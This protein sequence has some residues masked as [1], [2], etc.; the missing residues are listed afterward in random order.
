MSLKDCQFN[1]LSKTFGLPYVI[2]FGIGWAGKTTFIINKENDLKKL[3]IK[4]PLTL[5]VI[6]KYI[7]GFTV[8]NN[9]CIYKD[10]IYISPPAI[11]LSNIEGLST[12]EGETNGRQWPCS[13]IDNFQK[14]KIYDYSQVIG[15]LLKKSN[16][17]GYFG[18]DF[19]VDKNYG[20]VYLSELNARLTASSSF[21]TRLEY[22]KKLIPLFVYH[23]A[24]FLKLDVKDIDYYN[25]SDLIKGSQ[26]DIKDAII[27][28]KFDKFKTVGKFK[29]Y[30][31]Q[32][33][34]LNNIYKPELLFNN[35]FYLIKSNNK[36]KISEELVRLET[37]NSVLSTPNQLNG[38]F[39]NL[40][41]NNLQNS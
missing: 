36:D 29:N 21:Y 32:I 27:A 33:K 18:L 23:L 14:S 35:E 37:K 39:K 2:Q 13:F 3:Q 28:K 19:I 17:L 4:Y 5:A 11:Q 31:S 22:S 30:N 1:K 12:K 16:Y 20:K 25:Q 6:S 34:Y 9:C 24:G 8:L 41:N 7:V 15:N 10:N 38:W 40:L 26:V